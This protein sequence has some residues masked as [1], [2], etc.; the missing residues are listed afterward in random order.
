[1]DQGVVV[2]EMIGISSPMSP[3]SI[4]KL[5]IL[6]GFSRADIEIGLF[7]GRLIPFSLFFFFSGALL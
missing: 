7:R 3:F 6:F 5:S 4:E 2:E 1:M